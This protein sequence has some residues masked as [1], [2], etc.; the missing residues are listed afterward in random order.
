MPALTDDAEA[1]LLKNPLRPWCPFGF[2]PR[3]QSFAPSH[4]EPIREVRRACQARAV[5][6]CARCGY[7][8]PCPKGVDIPTNFEAYN[9]AFRPEDIP[10]ARTQCLVFI[11]EAGRADVW[12]ARRACEAGCLQ[13]I[14]IADG[15]PKLPA[16]PGSA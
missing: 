4:R 6:P 13:G 11:D 10:G 7:C 12:A 9:D 16:Q 5:I 15:M 2:P 8:M 14:P 1:K 3:S